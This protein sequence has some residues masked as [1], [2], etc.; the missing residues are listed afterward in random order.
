MSENQ[1][2]E[3]RVIKVVK[4]EMRS[5]VDGING[6]TRFVEDLGADELDMIEFVIALEEEFGFEIMPEDSDKFEKVGDVISH[7]KK[8]AELFNG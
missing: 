8:K 2:I 3:D 5:D 7:I 4:Y 1:S 6:D